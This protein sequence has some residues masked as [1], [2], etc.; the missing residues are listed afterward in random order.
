M[1][2]AD[3]KS[4]KHF[5]PRSYSKGK[6][7]KFQ[8]E[9]KKAA[10]KHQEQKILT[11]RSKPQYLGP[12]RLTKSVVASICWWARTDGGDSPEGFMQVFEGN[13][14]PQLRH[15]S[16]KEALEN[17][18]LLNTKTPNRIAAVFVSEEGQSDPVWIDLRREVLLP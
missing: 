4:F 1:I 2:A 13:G 16:S 15:P 6:T 17:P 3:S 9:T 11:K 18:H 12:I 8:D 14:Y 10:E 7:R 5:L